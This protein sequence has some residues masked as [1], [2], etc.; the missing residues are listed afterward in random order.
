MTSAINKKHKVNALVITDYDDNSNIVNL[1]S[2][3]AS[4]D[5]DL[6]REDST[7]VIF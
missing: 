1:Y 4:R 5:A 2:S 6:P 7:A 3:V